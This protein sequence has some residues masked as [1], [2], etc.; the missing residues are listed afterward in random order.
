MSRGMKW[1]LTPSQFSASLLTLLLLR[2]L[3]F[4]CSGGCGPFI[5]LPAYLLC[6]SARYEES[7]SHLSGGLQ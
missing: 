5:F 7:T 4:K 3:L 6:A 1:R 2:L